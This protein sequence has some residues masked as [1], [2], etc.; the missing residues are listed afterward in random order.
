MIPLIFRYHKTDI[1]I[2]YKLIYN[3]KNKLKKDGTALIQLE[4]YEDRTRKYISTEIGITPKFWDEKTSR[5]ISSHPRA[6]EYNLI[7]HDLIQ[8]IEAILRKAKLMDKDYSVDQIIALMNHEESSSLSEFMEKEIEKDLRIKAKTK[9]D[10][11]NTKNKI[12]DFNSNARLQDVD[13]KFIVDFDNYLKSMDYSINTIGKLH[14]NLKRFLNLAIKYNLI[15]PNDYA[16]RNFKVETESTKREALSMNEVIALEKLTYDRNSINEQVKDMFL[17]AC[18][19]GLRISDVIRL[20][21]S[22]CKMSNNGWRLEFKTFKVQKMAYLPLK[23]LF[24]DKYELS[25][26]ERIIDRY[27]NVNNEFVFPSIPESKIN[28][29]LKA[30]AAQAKIKKNV[31]F[32]MGRHTFGT[33][34]SSKI[35]LASLQ[36]LMQHS[37]IKTTM[38]YVNISNDIIDDN[39]GKVDWNE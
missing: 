31:T 34:M 9:T 8:K 17:F 24:K 10:L 21:N 23:N 29:Q 1:M 16:Y 11:L 30:I 6:E 2:K 28:R 7:L 5:V 14:K 4:F 18:Y 22:Y 13:Y 35:P 26:P 25:K 12:V 33:I 38:I 20:K 32:H 37:D 39:L 3:R 27:Y 36:S 19:T 15:S